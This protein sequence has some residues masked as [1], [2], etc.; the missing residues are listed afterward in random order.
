MVDTAAAPLTG[1]AAAIP[2][3]YVE[4]TINLTITLQPAQ[5]AAPGTSPPTFKGTA[6]NVI[7]VQG[8]GPAAQNGL[9]IGVQITKAGGNFLGLAVVQI[10]NLPISIMNQLSTLG[11]PLLQQV[12]VNTIVIEA[13]DATN[14]M[15][16]VF[17]G[18]IY[19]A[20]AAFTTD[21]DAVFHITAQVGAV[22]AAASTP[23]TTYSAPVSAAVVMADLAARGSYGFRNYGVTVQL[24]PTYLSGSLL[25]QIQQVKDAAGIEYSIDVPGNTLSIWPQGGNIDGLIPLVSATTGM[26]GYP[27]YTANGLSF[28][29]LFNASIGYAQRVQV[30]SILTPACGTFVVVYMDYDLEVQEPN[31]PWFMNVEAVPQGYYGTG[32]YGILT[33]G[34]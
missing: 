34:P 23:P 22:N 2:T 31:G 21:G 1:A 17:D 33:P 11:T 15:S 30:E 32:V 18:D 6:D 25:H 9:H 27:R 24:P 3:N 28:K 26:V 5:N 13:G 8:G 19:E 16:V 20:W 29:S 10:Y 14:G 7:K 12:G 4:R